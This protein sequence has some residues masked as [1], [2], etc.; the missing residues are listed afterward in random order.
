VDTWVLFNDVTG[1]KYIIFKGDQSSWS[2]VGI[3]IHIQNSSYLE[4]RLYFTDSTW[5]YLATSSL[6][7]TLTWHHIALVRKN[8]IVSLY[9]DGTL[10]QS[11][12]IGTKIM[13]SNSYPLYI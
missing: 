5:Q 4:T 11:A 6:P 3:D 7:T 2:T 9:L 13:Q 10:V 12:D 8:N 1:Y